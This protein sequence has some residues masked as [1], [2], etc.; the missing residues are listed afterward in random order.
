V[1]MPP[2]LLWPPQMRDGLALL[3][4][5]DVTE[6]LQPVEKA[7]IEIVKPPGRPIVDAQPVVQ[8]PA[9][10]LPAVQKPSSIL[11]TYS[12]ERIVLLS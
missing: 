8:A 11:S 7:A 3:P 6:T 1:R 12:S 4:I 5:A 2:A 10:E 9:L